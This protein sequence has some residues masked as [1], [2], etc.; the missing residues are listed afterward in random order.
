MAEIIDGVE[1]CLVSNGGVPYNELVGSREEDF[2]IADKSSATRLLLVPWNR[3]LD[4][5]KELLGNIVVVNGYMYRTPPSRYPDAPGLVAKRCQTK[6]RVPWFYNESQQAI[7]YKHGCELTVAYE[8]SDRE[9]DEATQD[10]PENREFELGNETLDYSADI[11]V[12]SGRGFVWENDTSVPVTDTTVGKVMGQI[13]FQMVRRFVAFVPEN[14]ITD[15]TGKTNNA[16][17]PPVPNKA[18]NSRSHPI[19]CVMFMGASSRRR[20]LFGQDEGYEVGYKFSIRTTTGETNVGAGQR[21]TWN[22]IY[23][24]DKGRWERPKTWKAPLRLMHEQGD[25]MRLFQPNAT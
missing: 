15:L 21:I 18:G 5:I 2:S 9:D 23:R 4:A 16:A 24:P 17:F 6:G 10:T 11:Q 12:L 25:L 8:T 22:H 20:I 7:E 14:T 1:Y 19:D 13:E 3:R